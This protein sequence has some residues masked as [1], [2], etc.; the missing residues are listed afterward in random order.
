MF[1]VKMFAHKKAQ[2]GLL[3]IS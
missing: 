3:V 1:A 2:W